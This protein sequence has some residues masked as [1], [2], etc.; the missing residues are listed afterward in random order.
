MVMV[1]ICSSILNCKVPD[2][3]THKGSLPD[4]PTYPPTK[5]AFLTNTYPPTKEAFQSNPLTH[6]QRSLPDNMDKTTHSQS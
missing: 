5:E 4:K 1:L 2:K 3:P 6:P